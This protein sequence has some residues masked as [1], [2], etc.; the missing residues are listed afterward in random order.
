MQLTNDQ[1]AAFKKIQEF[2]NNHEKTVFG[3]FGYG[4]TGKTTLLNRIV[5][6]YEGQVCNTASTNKATSVMKYFHKNFGSGSGNEEFV[7]TYKLFGYKLVPTYNA[8]EDEWEDKMVKSNMWDFPFDDQGM[9]PPLVVIDEC[10]EYGQRILTEN[11]WQK[12]GKLVNNKIKCRVWSLNKETKKLELKNI[13]NWLRKS[14]TSTLVEIDAGR[15]GSKR[16]ARLIRCTP[17]HKIFTPK[18][19]IEA[20]KLKIGDEVVVRGRELTSLQFSFLI[21]SMMGDAS[22]NRQTYRNSPQPRFIQ[23]DDQKDWLLF[24]KSIFGEDLTGPLQKGKSGYGPKP[25]W[26]FNLN[27]TDQARRVSEEMP[28]NKTLLNGRR[29]WTPT[30][31]FLS[32]I[33]ELALAVWYLDDG[34]ISYTP[35]KVPYISL[36]TEC[37]S[38]HTNIRISRFLKKRFLLNAKVRYD[39]KGHYFLSFSKEETTKL[40]KIVSPFIPKCMSYKSPLSDANFDPQFTPAY[41]ISKSPIRSI[42]RIKGK[43]DVY[44]LEVEDYHNYIAGNIVVSNCSMIPEWFYQR[45]LDYAEEFNLKLLFVGDSGQLPPVKEKTSPVFTLAENE[46]AHVLMKEIVRQSSGSKILE[47]ATNI[48]NNI[49]QEKFDFSI[50]L[51]KEHIL[52]TREQLGDIALEYFKKNNDFTDT[53]II[54]WRNKTVAWYNTYIRSS[55]R[56]PVPPKECPFIVGDPVVS[57]R[58]VY[59]GLENVLYTS[60]EMIVQAISESTRS[61]IKTYAVTLKSKYEPKVTVHMVRPSNYKTYLSKCKWYKT[62]AQ[63]SDDSRDW[64]I[65]RQF[66]YGFAELD[67][68]YAITSHRSQGST[69]KNVFIDMTDIFDNPNIEERN[70]CLYVAASRPTESIYIKQ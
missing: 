42:K 16:E 61:G 30:N 65:Y 67:F 20:G 9:F 31:K 40:L 50:I 11:G 21:G 27:V 56:G 63:R 17:N 2:L 43:E 13:T 44:D 34:S 60:Q 24:K 64:A 70:K 58:P 66:A 8:E 29:Y 54:A 62:K 53:K 32:W 52:K 28:L 4:G 7:T 55:L 12:I 37:F 1:E 15:T 23:G 41:E 59:K 47:V 6:R 3:F 36:H 35:T 69:Y 39:S 51:P 25:V 48:R 18:G 68:S 5:K 46:D 22:M 33:D 19:Y 14:T 49:L 38:K 57:K 26:N 10:F 45:L